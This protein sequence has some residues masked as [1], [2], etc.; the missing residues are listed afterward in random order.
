MN[1]SVSVCLNHGLRIQVH[2]GAAGPQNDC[3]TVRLYPEL[4]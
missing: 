3:E 1:F 2:P 4:P